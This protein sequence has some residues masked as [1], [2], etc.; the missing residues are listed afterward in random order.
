LHFFDI[1]ESYPQNAPMVKTASS[2]ALSLWFAAGVIFQ[3]LLMIGNKEK[4]GGFHY[5]N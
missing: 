1:S 2:M 4:L 5:N 3:A